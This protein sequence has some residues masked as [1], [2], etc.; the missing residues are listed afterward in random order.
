MSGTIVDRRSQRTHLFLVATLYCERVSNP[1]RVRNL[2]ASGALVEGAA[3]PPAGT[4]VILRR[5]ALE[6]Y[7]KT[8]WFMPGKAGLLFN[9]SLDV[10][11]WLPVKDAK[12]QTEIDR[13]AFGHTHAARPADEVVA[14]PAVAP[15]SIVP[16][17]VVAELL[18]LRADIDR[19]GNKLADDE[20][21]LANHP[22]VH[23]LNA[24]GQRIGRIVETLR[25]VHD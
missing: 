3:L 18:A 12:R 7:G 2:S 14:A 10:A 24:A 4:A 23:F 19:L 22:E 6:A 1:V 11:A 13:I 20:I 5:G 16:L 9:G 21:M 17:S 25:T 8:V 15:I